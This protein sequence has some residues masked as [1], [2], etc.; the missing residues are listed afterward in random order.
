MRFGTS[1][2]NILRGPGVVDL[3]LALFRRFV[4]R[5]RFNLEF[6]SEAANA[7]NTPHFNNPNSNISVANFLVVTSA[8]PDQRQIR[9]GLRLSW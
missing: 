3:G 2:R 8:Q 6:R 7:T 4:I 9:L 5:E 1:G